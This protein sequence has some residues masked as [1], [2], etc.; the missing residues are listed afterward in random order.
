MVPRQHPAA[1]HLIG[2]APQGAS[3]LAEGRIAGV[4]DDVELV[5]VLKMRAAAVCDPHGGAGSVG[6][7][8]CSGEGRPHGRRPGAGIAQS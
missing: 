3:G 6:G 4:G 7:V 2:A 8:A 5:Q 1:P